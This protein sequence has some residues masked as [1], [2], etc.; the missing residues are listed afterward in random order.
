MWIKTKGFIA[1]PQYTPGVDYILIVARIESVN[2]KLVSGVRSRDCQKTQGSVE[3]L[4]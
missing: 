3:T 4:I 1:Y 2:I